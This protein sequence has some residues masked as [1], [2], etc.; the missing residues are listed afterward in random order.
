[1]TVY[2]I[3]VTVPSAGL[4]LDAKFPCAIQITV[5]Y[6]IPIF[7]LEVNMYSKLPNNCTGR[8]FF[9]NDKSGNSK[10]HPLANVKSF[11]HLM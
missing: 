6:S 4:M 2:S 8:R 11:P 10:R 1:M 3:T 7:R 9:Y 5:F